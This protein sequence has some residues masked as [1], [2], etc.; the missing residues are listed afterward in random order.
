MSLITKNLTLPNS[1]ELQSCLVLNAISPNRTQ[2][3]TK[4]LYYI[5]KDLK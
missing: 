4:S 1:N 5:K 2:N 3:V